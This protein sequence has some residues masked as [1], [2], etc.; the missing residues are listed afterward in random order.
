MKKYFLRGVCVL[1]AAVLTLP[2]ASCGGIKPQKS[3]GDEL[4]VVATVDGQDIY[5]EEL[6]YLALNARADMEYKYGEGCFAD[7]EKGEALV[8]ELE[9]FVWSNLSKN[10]VIL[11]YAKELGIDPNN[12]DVKKAV[13][14][15]IDSVAESAGGKKGYLAQLEEN[16]M[17]DHLLR[18]NLQAS[19]VLNL[20][21]IEL[22]NNK[23]ID[24]SDEAARAVI[25]SDA[26]IRTLH[27]YVQND[28][29]EDVDANREKAQTAL[30]ELKAGEKLNSVIGRYSEDFYMTTTDGYYFTYGEYEQAYEDAAFALEVGEFSDIIETSSGFFII[31]R[32]E[33]DSEY[34]EKN[35]E[36]LKERYLYAQAEAILEQRAE[37]A[38]LVATDFGKS[39][40]LI[41][42]N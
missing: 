32:L 5:Y 18:F 2:L 14:S 3:K 19:Q 29:G 20:I 16:F 27:V 6:R 40:N 21:Q 24:G 33:K 31:Y 15:A 22:L 12:A 34:V 41:E 28:A 38:E 23:T 7:P 30:D 13:Q 35:F 42:I 1:L 37:K 26:F 36:S 10:T 25:E 4:K 17:T 39:L 11:S 9:D 8:A